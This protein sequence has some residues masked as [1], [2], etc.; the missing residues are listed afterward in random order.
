VRLPRA[1]GLTAVRAEAGAAS[2]TVEVPVSVAAR[3]R[4]RMG[5]GSTQVDETR[6]A[7]SAAGFESADYGT[8]PNRV[9]IDISGGVGSVR[10]IGVA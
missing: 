9:D 8:A 2:L 5:L 6:F 3:I 1:A 4:S 10:V 7:R